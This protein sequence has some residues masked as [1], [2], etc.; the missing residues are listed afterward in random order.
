MSLCSG[1]WSAYL[2][3]STGS[4]TLAEKGRKCRL[5]AGG[6]G[7]MQEQPLVQFPIQWTSRPLLSPCNC[8]F[9]P[10]ILYTG[11]KH[12]FSLLS[13][14]HLLKL[15]INY[16]EGVI[17][18]LLFSFSSDTKKILLFY[19]L[20]SLAL[21]CFI[22]YLSG[23]CVM[24]HICAHVCVETR[25]RLGVTSVLPLCGSW[26][27]NSNP[28]AWWSMP[29]PAEP[30]YQPILFWSSLTSVKSI[31]SLLILCICKWLKTKRNFTRK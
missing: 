6:D 20:V 23:M 21:F 25:E 30:F 8:S 7:W 4:L 2:L 1:V 10:C 29:L 15:M 26:K 17:S 13:S 27:L 9:F 28:H 11:A 22:F 19:F 14:D 16:N 3:P 18:R 12:F 5:K 31:F 24:C